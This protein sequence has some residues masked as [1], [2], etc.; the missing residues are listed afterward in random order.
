MVARVGR[1][2][3][4]LFKGHQG[5]TQGDPLPHTIFKV[6]VDTAIHHWV[7]L[8]TGEDAEPDG[9]GWAF[10]WLVAFFYSDNGLLASPRPARL[11]AHLEVLTGL[12]DRVVLH[13]NI[14]KTVGMVC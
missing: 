14:K 3:V 10:Q 13:T 5:V 11:Q 1:Y 2:D 9:F 8:V 4:N 7:T 12:F 6:A